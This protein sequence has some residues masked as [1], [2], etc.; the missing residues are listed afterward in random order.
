MK[1]TRPQKIDESV[2]ESSNIPVDAD[3]YE[4]WADGIIYPESVVYASTS[5]FVAYS[6]SNGNLTYLGAEYVE[7]V[8]S[9][10]T[11]MQMMTVSPDSRYMFIGA[12]SRT[13]LVL[14]REIGKISTVYVG[15][16]SSY[17]GG[18][19]FN[20]PYLV[21]A[22]GGN[23]PFNWFLF[24]DETLRP[25]PRPRNY[26]QREHQSATWLDEKTLY[27]TSGDGYSIEGSSTTFA[28]EGGKLR[29]VKLPQP[30]VRVVST[31]IW[32]DP[33]T[34]FVTGAWPD[35]Y[36]DTN[37]LRVYKYDPDERELSLIYSHF[38]AGKITMGMKFSPSGE[39]L[40]VAYYDGALYASEAATLHI[41][42]IG[43]GPTFTKL[44]DP[45]PQPIGTPRT[46]DWS[47]DSKYLF[48]SGGM[49]DNGHDPLYVYSRDEDTFTR[50]DSPMDVIPYSASAGYIG[51]LPAL[52]YF[53]GDV[54]RRGINIYE[55]LINDNQDN[56]PAT[57][58]TTLPAWL[59]LGKI[60][61]WRMFDEYLNTVSSN[62]DLIETVLVPSEPGAD[63]VAMYQ[64]KAESVTIERLSSSDDV[65]WTSGAISLS[66]RRSVIIEMD[67][68][69]TEG[70]KIRTSIS[71]PGQIV[72]CGKLVFGKARDVG[73]VEWGVEANVISYGRQRVDEFGR[74][75]L[76]PGNTAKQ[77]RA[78]AWIKTED[79]D[80]V[81]WAL[82]DL[83]NI[84]CVWDFNGDDTAFTTLEAYGVYRD[85]R[86][87][88][89]ES[90]NIK[91]RI[92]LL[93][94]I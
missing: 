41:H 79:V 74:A 29:P 23:P 35:G 84:P 11:Y 33:E 63:T 43:D 85:N 64:L 22:G 25:L 73:Q 6:H 8:P 46:I 52:G 80:D 77:I 44:P 71:N 38:G 40:A 37:K 88:F 53:A 42:K 31:A 62:P 78:T 65:L 51:F 45:E 83:E 49:V 89:K 72:E 82:E 9:D 27:V 7:G 70:E 28:L 91:L 3:G 18:L 1:V 30:S 50:V 48:I 21:S 14:K 12:Y 90:D 24:Q 76:R 4:E 15:P 59:D 34:L 56:D 54:I 47:E 20:E 67:Q 87:V 26:N 5:G 66:G 39:Y 10:N 61:R 60:N 57:Q 75:F 16:M 81:Y 19:A 13:I 94:L 68:A 32:K 17:L 58:S 69:L 92:D 86:I 36:S 55:S 93:G 2:L